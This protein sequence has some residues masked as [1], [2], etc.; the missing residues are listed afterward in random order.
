MTAAHTGE[1][2]PGA[3]EVLG[4]TVYSFA[5]GRVSRHE[6]CIGSKLLIN[7]AYSRREEARREGKRGRWRERKKERGKMGEQQ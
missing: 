7:T 3:A 2:Q 1:N 6:A 4:L 5:L